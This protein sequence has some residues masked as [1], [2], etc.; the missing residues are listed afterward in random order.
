MDEVLRAGAGS[1][2]FDFLTI[3]EVGCWI[4]LGGGSAVDVRRTRRGREDDVA[5]SVAALAINNCISSYTDICG[6]GV[7][8]IDRARFGSFLTT[9]VFFLGA[10]G[11]TTISVDLG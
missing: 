7:V 6:A 2:G 9:I 4:G 10:V 1:F 5:A 8:D 3:G 11:F